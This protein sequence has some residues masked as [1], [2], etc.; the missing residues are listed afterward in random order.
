MSVLFTSDLHFWHKNILG[1]TKRP[2]SSVEEMNECIVNIWNSQVSSKDTTYHLGDFAFNSNLEEVTKLLR[3]LNGS[4]IMI[5]GNH[6][7]EGFYRR[8]ADDNHTRILEVTHYKETKHEKKKLILSHFPFRSWHNMH[9]GS[10]NLHGHCHGNLPPQGKQLDVGVD[11][12]LNV[13][14]EFRLFTW[15]DIH[16]FMSGRDIEVVDH[17]SGD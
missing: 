10:Y 3:R 1:Y 17:H 12:A 11:N 5:L 13:L 14:G 6:D 2:F 8:I 9:Y 16:K 7:R 4:K 15:D